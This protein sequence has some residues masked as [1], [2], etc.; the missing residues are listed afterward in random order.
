M[1]WALNLIRAAYQE[2]AS[3]EFAYAGRCLHSHTRADVSEVASA[4][5]V[6]M[7]TFA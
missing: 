7:W 3:R 6:E 2:L 1:G 5:T 4:V